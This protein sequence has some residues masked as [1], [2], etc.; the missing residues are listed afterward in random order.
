M[1]PRRIY[2]AAKA[3]PAFTS[4]ARWDA[5]AAHCR[6]L[7]SVP[8]AKEELVAADHA[9]DLIKGDIKRARASAQRA[10][11]EK[12]GSKGGDRRAAVMAHRAANRDM[13]SNR[14]TKRTNIRDYKS[15]SAAYPL[16]PAQALPIAYIAVALVSLIPTGWLLVRDQLVVSLGTVWPTAV[17]VPVLIVA[18]LVYLFRPGAGV[19]KSEKA[20][21]SGPTSS[22][23]LAVKVQ[24]F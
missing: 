13:S 17:L 10:A 24:D 18:H 20:A 11:S 12:V 6:D 22:D 15:K 1:E 8:G 7:R 23:P 4:R 16:M 9:L 19:S 14:H 21:G 5:Y 2:N 3:A